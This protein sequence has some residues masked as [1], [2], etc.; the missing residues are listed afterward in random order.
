MYAPVGDGLQRLLVC[1]SI[2]NCLS[3]RWLKKEVNSATDPTGA[4]ERL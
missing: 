3:E 2:L 1:T 4:T